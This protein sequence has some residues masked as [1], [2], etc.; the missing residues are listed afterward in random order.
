MILCY[1]FILIASLVHASSWFS[2]DP[3]YAKWSDAELRSWLELHSIQVPASFDKPH[4]YDLVHANWQTP[5]E[6]CAY[7][8]RQWS[9]DQY[10]K[11]QRAFQHTKDDTFDNWDQGRLR[12]FLLEQ[13][14]VAPSGPREQL[15]LLA[16]NKYRA[17]TDAAA[18]YSS[19]ASASASSAYAGATDA[20]HSASQCIS[21]VAAHATH[22]V[23]RTLDASK[24]YVYSDWDDSQLRNWLQEHGVVEAKSAKTKD[25]LTRLAND[26]Y[27]KTSSAVWESWSDSYIVSVKLYLTRFPLPNAISAG[28]AYCSQS[29]EPHRHAF[30]IEPSRRNEKVLLQLHRQRLEHVVRLRVESLAGQSRL[31]EE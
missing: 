10:L 26:Y 23:A 5:L 4:L 20:A 7:A 24:D 3:E 22:E 18:L 8:G 28:M 25:E 1:Y 16:K 14:V 30:S 31:L 13:G 21:S 9:L 12:V 17:Y 15:A 29:L 6:T 19:L 2:T 27:R 11:A